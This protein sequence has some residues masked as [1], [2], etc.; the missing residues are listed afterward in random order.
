MLESDNNSVFCC[1]FPCADDNEEQLMCSR[2]HLERFVMSRIADFAFAAVEI[3]EEDA[4]LSRRM[5][6]LSFLEPEVLHFARLHN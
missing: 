6:V 4:L 1:L 2:D 5:K 3:P